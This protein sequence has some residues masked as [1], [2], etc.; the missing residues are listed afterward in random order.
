MSRASRVMWTLYV[1]LAKN[2]TS[3]TRTLN[4]TS[5]ASVILSFSALIFEMNF[6][7]VGFLFF[8]SFGSSL[9]LVLVVSRLMTLILSFLS[10]CLTTLSSLCTRRFSS[11]KGST[12]A[13]FAIQSCRSG[14]KFEETRL[15]PLVPD[16]MM[17]DF[18]VFGVENCLSSGVPFEDWFLV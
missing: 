6:A 3:S 12:L 4:A 16:W 11:T 5:V 18:W 15:Y 17:A 7:T 10:D 2:V 9:T 13:P 1:G 14:W 8:M